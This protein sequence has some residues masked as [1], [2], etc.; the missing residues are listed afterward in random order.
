MFHHKYL[1]YKTKYLQ[2]KILQEGG[3]REK[4]YHVNMGDKDFEKIIIQKLEKR[5]FVKG[6]KPPFTFIFV[7]HEAAFQR[8]SF[9]S[10]GSN[11]I[12]LIQGES[13]DLIT[14]KI[15]LHKK[16]NESNFMKKALFLNSQDKNKMKEEVKD[17][18]DSY[19]ILKPLK[20]YKG[21]GIK[22]VSNKKD[23]IDWIEN[24]KEYEDWI[25]EDYIESPDLVD[26]Y[27]FHLR[28]YILVV[29]RGNKSAEVYVSF[30]KFYVR[31]LEK[32]KKEDWDNKSIHDT[33]F[34]DSIKMI[35]FDEKLPDN[36]EEKDR[37]N[38]NKK[39]N[40]IIKEIFSSNLKFW[41]E[42]RSK[43]SFEVFGADVIFEN[44]Q[45]KILEINA[46][47]AWFPR[48]AEIIDPLLD[49][50]LDRKQNKEFYKIY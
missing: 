32:Y 37:D 14:N 7:T 27:K 35:S 18:E 36:W 29:V 49:I 40:E 39:I 12:N 4:T 31:A 16:F 46:K 8:N 21:K 28:V 9:N 11:W 5:K 10:M 41:Q 33:H 1:K 34:K 6:D 44:K 26:S 17:L 22:V 43:N 20:G 19:R 48:T 13:K 50:V 23:M 3:K 15:E 2:L 25:V 47:M 38:A 45:P 42:W 24:N 30:K